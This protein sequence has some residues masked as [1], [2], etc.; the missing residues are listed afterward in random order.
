MRNLQCCV[1]RSFL[2]K[3]SGVAVIVVA[4]MLL[5]FPLTAYADDAA[6]AATYKAKCAMCH[7]ADGAG[8]T[9]MGAKLSIPNLAGPEVQKKPDTSLVES[10]TKGK[11]RMPE[12]GSKL[13]PDQIAQVKDYIREIAKKP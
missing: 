3:V 2:I 7:G 1:S 5:C 13:T 11:N 9:P 12:F 8:K 6:G 4:L 10:I